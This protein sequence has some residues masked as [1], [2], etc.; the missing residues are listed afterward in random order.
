MVVSAARVLKKPVQLLPQ[1]LQSKVLLEALQQVFH[2][3]LE[4][5][6]FEFLQDRWLKVEIR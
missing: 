4:D 6:D 5:G 3:A 2:E 1:R